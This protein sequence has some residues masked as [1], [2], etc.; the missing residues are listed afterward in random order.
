[1]CLEGLRKPGEPQHS[2][3][4]GPDLT[5]H[6]RKT[7]QKYYLFICSLFDDAL[8]NSVYSVQ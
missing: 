7:S 3:H 4:R 5:V 6:L 1:M 2:W 8:D